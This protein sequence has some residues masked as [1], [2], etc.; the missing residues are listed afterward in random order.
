MDRW[1]RTCAWLCSLGVAVTVPNE[2]RGSDLVEG[3]WTSTSLFSLPS[4][5][6]TGMVHSWV[7][8]LLDRRTK[9]EPWIG[10]Q[11]NRFP[12]DGGTKRIKQPFHGHH[13]P[14]FEGSSLTPPRSTMRHV[15]SDRPGGSPTSPSLDHPYESEVRYTHPNAS[16]RK[17]RL[18]IRHAETKRYEIQWMPDTAEPST[19]AMHVKTDVARDRT[20]M[21]TPKVREKTKRPVELGKAT[22]NNAVNHLHIANPLRH[23]PF[24][25]STET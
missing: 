24:P 25:C 16:H 11:R 1:R 3:G 22:R 10:T 23:F 13:P 7:G 21:P 18:S 15:A 4:P 9:R 5:S 8:F 6:P 12:F 17:A 19:N 20:S 2:H 14:P